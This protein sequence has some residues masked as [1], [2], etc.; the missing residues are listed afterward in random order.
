MTRLMNPAGANKTTI[1]AAVPSLTA[2]LV[3]PYVEVQ[4]VAV[5]LLCSLAVDGALAE[6]AA[7][8]TSRRD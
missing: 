7:A 8:A 4:L 1:S 5:E 3:S 6:T 2:L